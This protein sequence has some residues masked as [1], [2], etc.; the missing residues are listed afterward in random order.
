MCDFAFHLGLVFSR[1][2]ARAILFFVVMHQWPE[3][4]PLQGTRP[5]RPGCNRGRAWAGSMRLGSAVLVAD[6]TSVVRIQEFELNALE[7]LRAESSREGFR[8]VERLCDEWVSGANRF[9]APGEALFV[10]VADGQ[11]VGVCGLN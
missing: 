2:V 4:I 10:A 5:S 7:E 3:T 1:R 8:F 9:N 11:V 6:M